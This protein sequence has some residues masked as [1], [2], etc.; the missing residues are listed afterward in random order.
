MQRLYTNH[1]V[2]L[3]F[4]ANN[5]GADIRIGVWTDDRDQRANRA[6]YILFKVLLFTTWVTILRND[7]KTLGWFALHPTLQTLALSFFT[8]GTQSAIPLRTRS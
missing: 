5:V 1:V 8:Y 7:P 3:S 2:N 4:L 6:Q